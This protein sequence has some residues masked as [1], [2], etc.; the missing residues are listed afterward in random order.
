MM[1]TGRMTV[2]RS[3]VLMPVVGMVLAVIAPARVSASMTCLP[4]GPR[5][6]GVEQSDF[7]R[8]VE[9]MERQR[10][11]EC[12]ARELAAQQVTEPPITARPMPTGPYRGPDPAIYTPTV[13]PLSTIGETVPSTDDGW[14]AGDVVKGLA[15]AVGV[16]IWI[17]GAASRRT[18]GSRRR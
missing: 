17:V 12:V 2:L 11:E 5:L 4:P 18:S 15:C 7:D 16:G 9:E 8:T 14:S 10:F 6:P 3:P 13:A 1:Q